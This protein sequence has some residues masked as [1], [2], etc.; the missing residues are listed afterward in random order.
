MTNI[1]TNAMMTK[2][3]LG[4]TIWD[5]YIKMSPK[6][7]TMVVGNISALINGEPISRRI[8]WRL[9]K[10]AL[11]SIKLNDNERTQD[12]IKAINND[13]IELTNIIL[14]RTDTAGHIIYD[15]FNKY[16][17]TDKEVAADLDN[18]NINKEETKTMENN[19]PKLTEEAKAFMKNHNLNNGVLAMNKAIEFLIDLED[20]LFVKDSLIADLKR[21]LVEKQQEIE[22]EEIEEIEEI[23]KIVEI[24]EIEEI[25]NN[26][27][28]EDKMP[29]PQAINIGELKASIKSEILAELREELKASLTPNTD[30]PI[31]NKEDI[32]KCFKSKS[33]FSKLREQNKNKVILQEL[34]LEK[35]EVNNK[36]EDKPKSKMEIILEERAKQRELRKIELEKERLEEESLLI[37]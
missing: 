25:D 7:N 12:N 35:K 15:L 34:E 26:P 17:G 22:I 28:P 16:H 6:T 27:D 4:N 14:E 32:E 10:Y 31:V 36:T 2:A 20:R 21:D 5:L 9:D 23:V 30:T 13:K 3:Q 19:K 33:S 37:D 24:E 29:I 1:N 18:K 8:T 11:C